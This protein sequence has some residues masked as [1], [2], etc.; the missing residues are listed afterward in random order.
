MPGIR[1][2]DVVLEHDRFDVAFDPEQVSRDRMLEAVRGLGF[3]ATVVATP[4]PESAPVE[5]ARTELT[6]VARDALAE[7][8]RTGRLVLLYFT[9][10][11]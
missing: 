7:A 2:L 1:Q 11:G 6:G 3:E 9:G 8:S 4:A 5:R 10:P